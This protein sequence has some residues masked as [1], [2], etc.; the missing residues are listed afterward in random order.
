MS[1]YYVGSSDPEIINIKP[2][3]NSSKNIAKDLE[4]NIINI[5]TRI[6][7]KYKLQDSVK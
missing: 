5:K 6:D 2:D 4:D 1:I 7:E 3:L